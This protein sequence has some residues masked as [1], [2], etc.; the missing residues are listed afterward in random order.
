M[1]ALEGGLLDKLKATKKRAICDKGY[2][3][4]PDYLCYANAYDS[5][6]V[7]QFKRRARMR[8]EKFNGTLKTFDCLKK[9]FRH[10]KDRLGNCV[11]AVA[12]IAQYMMELGEPLFNI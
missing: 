6:E 5:D 10:G 11:E 1:C 12:V 9:Q 4:H 2:R 8:H 7:K 3:G